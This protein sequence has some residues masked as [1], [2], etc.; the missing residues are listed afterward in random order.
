MS[1]IQA[2]T[3][4]AP[5]NCEGVIH[6]DAWV[7]GRCRRVKHSLIDLVYRART[8]RHGLARPIARVIVFYL[9]ADQKRYGASLAVLEY[10]LSRCR[11]L[12][13]TLITIDNFGESKPVTRPSDRRYDI[14]GD[15]SQWEFSGWKTGVEFCRQRGF[16]ADIALF[17]NDSFLNWADRKCDLY[18]CRNAFNTLTLAKARNIAF[19]RV[20]EEAPGTVILGHP[21]G[22]YLQTHLFAMPFSLAKRLQFTYL[23]ETEISDL[24]SSEFRDEWFLGGS[25]KMVSEVFQ[26]ELVH[27]L[28]REWR[29]G[30]A[31]SESNWPLLRAKSVAMIN[32]RLL[33]SE[34][35][36]YNCEIWAVG[37]GRVASGC[38]AL[39]KW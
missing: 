33:S 10:M 28:R 32:E 18:W 11:G 9:Y 8:F 2:T 29:G 19:G 4:R 34:I 17:V 3:N 39:R 22:R 6:K 25:E 27:Y 31:P 5:I 37:N 14:G 26:R 36:R 16:D 23:T 15:N 30:L 7:R 1:V 24:M 13:I 21:I 12:D 35:E 38:S 20:F